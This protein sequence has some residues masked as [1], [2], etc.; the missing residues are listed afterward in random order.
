MY[1]QYFGL[2]EA[3]FSIA[4][5]P[6]YLFM[7]P[8]H[9]DALAH[10]L[11]GVGTGGFILLTGE[12]GTGKTTINRCLLEQMPDDTDIA[13]ILNPALNAIELL[14]SVCDEL[15]IEVESETPS[16]KALTDAL[17]R[18][19]LEN[20]ARGRKTVLLIDEAQH[21]SFDVLEQIRLLT[22]LETNSEKLLQIVLIG[23]PELAA[24]LQRP[25]LRQLNQR[26][27]ARYNLEPL[28]YDETRAYIRHRLQVAGLTADRELFSDAVVRA[29]HRRT[30]GIPRL[31]NVL[32]DRALLG[33]Y[34]QN[35]PRVDRAM[36]AAAARE[37]MGDGDNSRVVGGI[38]G[39]PWVMPLA[40]VLMAAVALGAW[41]LLSG[42]DRTA[43][44]R[45]AT[46]A[47]GAIAG[48]DQVA[49]PGG[50][51]GGESA[52]QAQ[53]HDTGTAKATEGVGRAAF[54]P[55]Q[56]AAAAG[57]ATPSATPSATSPASRERGIA[58]R[59]WLVPPDT[60]ARLL[61][62]QHAVARPPASACPGQTVAGLACYR[63][64]ERSWSALAAYD[65]PLVMELQTPEGFRAAALFIGLAGP[66]ARLLGEEG[67]VEV[68]LTELAALW[69]GN[70]YL[71]WRPPEAF[72]GPLS[73]GDSGPA[74][75]EIASM[76]ARLD[77][78]DRPLSTGA[79]NP[80]LSQR[81][82]LFQQ[83]QGLEADGVVGVRTLLALNA[84]LGVDT[85]AALQHGVMAGQGR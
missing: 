42:R 27:T 30:Q 45:A 60:A 72:D 35:R 64:S 39:R 52:P 80:A 49:I 36:V 79:F 85:H 31:I 37:V 8:R 28:S 74:V 62:S 57:S 9:R 22:N 16:L 18:F 75:A 10:L 51:S 29:I 3:P 5:N 19:L 1:H 34:G 83:S 82:R 63:G 84:A 7:S 71:L 66:N 81:V 38:G 47:A 50:A 13:I 21:L 54:V 76:L 56:P 32:C 2:T 17:H 48:H 59:D 65:R 46:P 11:Y 70:F 6:R 67:V 68:P 43:T 78:Q 55:D 12:V 44:N 15:G 14:A 26:I 40:L 20:H 33:A 25:E 24:M 69:S 58:L 4:V 41:W 23:Q 61:W 77:G 53:T 73:A